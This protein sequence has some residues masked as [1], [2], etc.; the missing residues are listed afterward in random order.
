MSYKQVKKK[1]FWYVIRYLQ[2]QANIHCG[3]ASDALCLIISWLC[4]FPAYLNNFLEL[5]G[6][7]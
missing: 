4:C 5:F 2:D 6:N 3:F 7:F 1:Y